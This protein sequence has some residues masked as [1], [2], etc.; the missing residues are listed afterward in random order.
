MENSFKWN[1]NWNAS[2]C[3]VLS[4]LSGVWLFATLF[5]VA[6]QVLLSMGFYRQECWNGLSLPS[7]GD[8][9]NP[10]TEPT[11]LMLPALAGRFFTTNKNNVNA[12]IDN[13]FSQKQLP[14]L[15][16]TVGYSLKITGLNEPLWVLHPSHFSKTLQP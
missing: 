5:T 15:H 8:L 14:D 2:M 12:L 11:S 13:C 1:P 4:H 6:L 9:S 3:Y 10:R 7:P 16:G